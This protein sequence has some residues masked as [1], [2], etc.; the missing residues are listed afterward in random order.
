MGHIVL[1]GPIGVGKS[2]VA[3]L[4]GDRL[5][6]PTVEIDALRADVYGALGYDNP[7]ADEILQRDG[8]TGLTNYWKPF[9]VA[10]VERAVTLQPDAVL[11][12]GAGHS[13][14]DDE[15]F[16][17]RAS[18]ALAAHYVV[19]LLPSPDVFESEEILAARSPEQRREVTRQLNVD[20]VRSR[21]NVALAD[22]ILVTGRRSPEAVAADLVAGWLQVER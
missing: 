13:H 11:D 4:V 14:F 7:R 12:F 8:I 20:F 5:G 19:L 10:L 1:I 16:F 17:I 21:S 22:R 6:R 18:A 2:T 3:P 15:T 9:E